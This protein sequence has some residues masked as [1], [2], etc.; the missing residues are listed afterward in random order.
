MGGSFSGPAEGYTQET[1]EA[2]PDRVLQQT[3]ATAWLF[4]ATPA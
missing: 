1:V 2:L 3:V 4:V